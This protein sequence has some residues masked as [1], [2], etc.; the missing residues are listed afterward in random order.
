MIS[1]KKPYKPLLAVKPRQDIS[2]FNSLTGLFCL[3]LEVDLSGQVNKDR[4]ASF[5]NGPHPFL[6][7]IRRDS[8]LID[9]E[10]LRLLM[11]CLFSKNYI[12]IEDWPVIAFYYEA[13]IDGDEPGGLF[14]EYLASKLRSQGWPSVIQWHF[15]PASFGKQLEQK[16]KNPLL[17]RTLDFNE[18]CLEHHFFTDYYYVD[19]Y[20]LFKRDAFGEALEL[21]QL[22]FSACCMVLGRNDLLRTG[23]QEYLAARHSAKE[24]NIKNSLLQER[25]QNAEKTIDI[26]RT[27]YKDDYDSLFKWY[28]NEYEILPLWYK[29]FGH[30]LKVLMGKRTFRSLFYD[31]VKKYRN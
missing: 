27:K 17:V 8:N 25:L 10:T 28:H 26:I 4:I 31:H 29:R 30:I 16:R 13:E 15:S 14:A 19:N 23:L 9:P 3:A 2:A 12:R 5:I 1:I 24:L 18:D 11:L 6:L 20:I 7:L 21:E 22:F